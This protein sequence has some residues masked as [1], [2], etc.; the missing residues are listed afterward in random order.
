MG[1]LDTGGYRPRWR[2]SRLQSAVFGSLTEMNH[3]ADGS[4]VLQDLAVPHDDDGVRWISVVDPDVEQ[5]AFDH[6]NQTILQFGFE[7]RPHRADPPVVGGSTL[8]P[9][10][11]YPLNDPTRTVRLFLMAKFDENGAP[12]FD[13]PPLITPNL[14]A[15]VAQVP[16]GQRYAYQLCVIERPREFH[17]RQVAITA[18]RSGLT[19]QWFQPTEAE[20]MVAS[21]A[22]VLGSIEAYVRDDARGTPGDVIAGIEASTLRC[23]NW[24]QAGDPV[25]QHPVTAKL[26]YVRRVGDERAVQNGVGPA[27]LLSL[28]ESHDVLSAN[29]PATGRPAR[30]YATVDLEAPPS[31]PMLDPIHIEL[32]GFAGL[33]PTP[34]RP[35]I[36]AGYISGL[37]VYRR[38][39]SEQSPALP[40]SSSVR[41]R[42]QPAIE[43]AAADD[44]TREV[45]VRPEWIQ[46]NVVTLRSHRRTRKDRVQA[47][48]HQ[49]PAR[50]PM[51]AEF[52]TSEV[53]DVLALGGFA[54][55]AESW[56][57]RRGG[58][59]RGTNQ[60]MVRN[61]D[62][63]KLS[64]VLETRVDGLTPMGVRSTLSDDRTPIALRG[65][66][67]DEW[68]QVR[69]VDPKEFEVSRTLPGT[70][71]E[72][73]TMF[74]PRPVAYVNDR[75]QGLR[76]LKVP[77]V[78]RA[79]RGLWA[80]G[81]TPILV[82]PP[83][84]GLHLALPNDA[85]MELAADAIGHFAGHLR[86]DSDGELTLVLGRTPVTVRPATDVEVEKFGR[87]E[88]L[89]DVSAKLATPV[90]AVEW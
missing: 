61:T 72:L 67:D 14:H 44:P 70:L 30:T 33:W 18:H 37:P 60:L 25:T 45:G 82:K 27:A 17:D 29:D 90:K 69:F 48:P 26:G 24:E 75:R 15:A 74:T 31:W 53:F 85:S 16:P 78:A 80:H 2:W 63:S 7:A 42:R 40:V 32:P 83:K 81:L 21:N 8:R 20:I 54:A 50:A 56:E 35:D 11:S 76:D 47:E 64:A 19:A 89:P 6:L 52:Y 46:G 38:T 1:F 87:I 65:R 77:E 59:R 41:D 84:R 68:V 5:A 62:R 88:V 10:R 43:P 71:F 79:V 55:R 57:T 66:V 49:F 13:D 3:D 34:E 86:S 22:I 51:Y 12:N 58:Q 36:R 28:P 23:R 9:A 39:T 4:P 73:G